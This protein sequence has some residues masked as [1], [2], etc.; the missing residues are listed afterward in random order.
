[1]G[2]YLA[3]R[4]LVSIPVLLGITLLTFLFINLAPGD[5][6]SVLVDP[7]LAQRMPPE[8][9]EAQRTRL[10]LDKPLLTRYLIWLDQLLHGNMG[11]SIASSR[12]VGNMIAERLWNTVS[13]MGLSLVVGLGLGLTVGIISAVKQY[14]WF[15]HF[16]TLFIFLMVSIPGFFKALILIFIFALTL[17]WLP[18]SGMNTIG[19]GS[20][21]WDSFKHLILPVS[22]ISLGS[23]AEI[24]RYMRA[25]L[26]ETIRE[27]YIRAAT[28]K[29][30]S[31]SAILWRHAIPNAMIPVLTIAGLQLPSLFNG[32]VI[33]EQIF[34]WQG[35]GLLSIRA[36]QGQDYP[37]LMGIILMS[38]FLVLASNMLTDI[39]Y[40][41]VDPRIRY[42]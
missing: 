4:V 2:R 21:L 1:M 39:S 28:G 6:V 15:D 3:R 29:G 17:K 7:D 37:V 30:L 10:G 26:L 22:V 35:I 18:T 32:A 23:A 13:L 19:R 5:P 20:T 16:T 24:A 41:I 12:P 33:A 36:V 11:Y 27:D 14:S 34:F 31:P 9:F 40:A 25:S 42:S 8:W 38:A